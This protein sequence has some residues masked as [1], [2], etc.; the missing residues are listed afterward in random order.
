MPTTNAGITD[1]SVT[2]PV[3]VR[4]IQVVR[5]SAATVPS[6]NP[7][8]TPM[9]RANVATDRLTPSPRPIRVEMSAPLVQLVPSCPCSTPPNQ[10]AY[11]TRKGRSRPH[12]ASTRAMASGVASSPSWIRAGLS[13][14]SER[15][16]NV[17][18][19]ATTNTGTKI[20]TERVRTARTR[21]SACRVLAAATPRR[22]AGV[23]ACGVVDMGVPPLFSLCVVVGPSAAVDGHA[24]PR[25]VGRDLRQA[26]DRRAFGDQVGLRERE[27]QRPALQTGPRRR[28]EDL[29]VLGESSGVRRTLAAAASK[30]A[31]W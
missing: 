31:G 4:S 9:T 19:V 10:S 25:D 18:N 11:W 15:S 29:R 8:R 17:T 22:R 21:S 7:T 28:L 20:S 2:K 27:D 3:I 30:P 26:G 16:A 23:A 5:R 14:L 13:P 6:R 24:G 12:S 1:T